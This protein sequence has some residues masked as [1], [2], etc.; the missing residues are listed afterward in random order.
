M[1]SIHGLSHKAISAFR[2][3]PAALAVYWIYV[4]RT[5][6][7]G[8]AWPSLRGLVHDTGWS[9]NACKE[10]R[11]WLVE[12]GALETV[13]EYIRP[14]W[15]K[16]E[17]D[18]KTHTRN[19]D[20]SEYYRVTGNI[21]VNAKEYAMLYFGSTEESD[22]DNPTEPDV[23]PDDTTGDITDVSPQPTSGAVK[24]ASGDTELSISI[25][26]LDSTNTNLDSSS[27]TSTAPDG[28][29]GAK[30]PVIGFIGQDAKAAATVKE[31]SL[32]KPDAAMP[33]PPSSGAP[34]AP[35]K[36][37]KKPEKVSPYT[38]EEN[39]AIEA[40]FYPWWKGCDIP[41]RPI[42]CGWASNRDL[43]IILHK[44]GI[45]PDHVQTYV[46][47][48]KKEAYW[49]DDV[50]PWTYLYKNITTWLKGRNLLA[51]AP[52]PVAPKP[53]T[54]QEQEARSAALKV[55]QQMAEQRYGKREM[56]TTNPFAKDGAK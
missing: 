56:L 50:L 32:A 7:E 36:T 43:A 18:D 42:D 38:P 16:L 49:K 35:K 25:P 3:K 11:K 2:D 5:N 47:A 44:A 10:A 13:D 39:K 31:N 4:S 33:P 48:K 20:H 8:V 52:T 55:Q 34:P 30:L 6:N 22:I 1:T 46:E 28:T 24:Q 40:L 45:T 9:I 17:G 41:A 37:R 15:R 21:M 27:N 12:H 29:D 53:L 14:R 26:E 51:P 19:I 23:S 54:P